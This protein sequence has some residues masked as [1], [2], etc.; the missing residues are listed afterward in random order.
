MLVPAI[1]ERT[2]HVWNA[3]VT[4][5]SSD[6]TIA[7]FRCI[8]LLLYPPCKITNGQIINTKLHLYYASLDS[9]SS[10]ANSSN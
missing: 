7:L 3:Q 8:Q 1:I 9:E 5:E 10:P 2:A 6:K 4:D